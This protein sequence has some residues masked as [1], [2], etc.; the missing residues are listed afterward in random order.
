[1]DRDFVLFIV[2][3][4]NDLCGIFY[5]AQASSVSQPFIL[6]WT[7]SWTPALGGLFVCECVCPRVRGHDPI[8]LGARPHIVRCIH[9]MVDYETQ[10]GLICICR[11][12]LGGL[13]V[14]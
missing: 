12:A 11:T 7:T 13:F 9:F 14:C 4:C 1:M 6:V 2:L 8:P 10:S 3:F 5:Y